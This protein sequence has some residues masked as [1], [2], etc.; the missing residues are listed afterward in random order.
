M[1]NAIL[2]FHF[3]FLTPSLTKIIYFSHRCIS[4]SARGESTKGAPTLVGG[5]TTLQLQVFGY[6]SPK[7]GEYAH[8]FTSIDIKR[9]EYSHLSTTTNLPNW[10]QQCPKGVRLNMYASPKRTRQTHSHQIL[11]FRPKTVILDKFAVLNIICL[12]FTF[13]SQ[14]KDFVDAQEKC[15]L[16]RTGVSKSQIPNIGV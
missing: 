11:I 6:K 2:N 12:H 5:K 13:A 4:S 1:A 9:I 3:D 7:L 16:Y 10:R 15:Q 14:S 8:F